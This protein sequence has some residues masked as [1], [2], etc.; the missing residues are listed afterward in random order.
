VVI[1]KLVRHKFALSSVV[2]PWIAPELRSE[3]VRSTR[4]ARMSLHLAALAVALTAGCG[5]TGVEGTTVVDEGCPVLPME[6]PC[7]Q[8]PLPARVLVLNHKGAEIAHTNTNEKG[9]FRIRLS[10]GDYVLQGQNLTGG[11]LPSA[12]PV[13]VNVK[14]GRMQAV[15]IQF[16]SGVRAPSTR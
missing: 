4:V 16:D 15:T 12:T 7:P 6:S 3:I 8:R 13:S 2:R 14:D 10:A 1:P 5:A 11:P 9:E